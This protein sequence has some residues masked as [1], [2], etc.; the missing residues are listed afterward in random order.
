[1][2]SQSQNT[3]FQ[4]I[5]HCGNLSS[6]T[7]SADLQA[8]FSKVAPVVKL[9]MRRKTNGA[10]SFAFAYFMTI[11]DAENVVKECNYHDLN[12][13]QINLM[14]Y[15]ADKELPE[16]ANIFVKNLPPT[17]NSKD[18]NEIFK[19]FGQIVSCKVA[20]NEKGE[21]KGFGYVQYKNPKSAKKAIASCKNVK[22]GSY[23]LEVELYDP[24][25]KKGKEI[26]SPA[27]TV[28][29]NC[30]VKN[31]PKSMKEEDLK[32]ILEKHGKVDSMYFPKNEDETLVGY[33]CANFKTPE[34]AA[35]AID[36][37]HGKNI[38]SVEEMGKEEGLIPEPFY[39]QKAEN[40]KER[41]EHLK[42]QFEQLMFEGQ[43]SKRNLYVSN[44]P[45]TFTTEEIKTLFLKFGV[46]TD[47]KISSNPNS[48][49][50]YGYVCYSTPEE[51]CIAF[52]K[53]DGT[54][55]DENKLQISYYK[56][57]Y[58]RAAEGEKS[59]STLAD[60]MTMLK[61][62]S[63]QDENKPN[64]NKKSIQNLYNSTLSLANNFKSQWNV[65]TA[66]TQDEFTHEVMKV[67]LEMPSNLI[68]DLSQDSNAI[69]DHI[70][71]IIHDKKVNVRSNH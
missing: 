11:Q 36:M 37:L 21:L 68:K 46:I 27:K 48:T 39:I 3:Q 61:S 13:K 5:V 52:E 38:F 66:S 67:M 44:I 6:K 8:L 12:G 34:E 17:L 16:G 24:K 71:K 58:E 29:T 30:F 43:R 23:T 50:Q 41:A 19:M 59:S 18:L 31:F 9:N 14:L 65:F 63:I 2:D 53:L 47:F 26:T 57:K 69:E 60:S 10:S 56:N 64:T 54:L 28:F 33:G 22:I 70:R 49:K 55:L 1:M 15:N 20:S 35:N 45:D 62:L 51:A 4:P 32:Q 42:K 7:T 40:K 25:I